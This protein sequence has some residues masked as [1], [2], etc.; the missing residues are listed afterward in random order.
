MNF[1]KPTDLSALEWENYVIAQLVQAM[2]GL[3]PRH[4][5]AIGI[6]IHQDEV[7]IQ[8]QLAS[9]D[10]RD[11]ADIRDIT[12]QLETLLGEVVEVRST[13]TVRVHPEISPL[14]GISWVY[15]AR[16]VDEPAPG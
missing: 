13:E 2:L 3:I 16:D 12:D 6:A 4:A 14:V 10:Q 15:R 1:P 8:F 9:A 7:E 11:S 5:L